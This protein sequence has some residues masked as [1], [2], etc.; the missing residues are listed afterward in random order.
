MARCQC[1]IC[2]INF[3]TTDIFPSGVK[4]L[5]RACH[6]M[7]V[8]GRG[9]IQSLVRR[10]LPR[11]IIPVDINSAMAESI[12]EVRHNNGIRISDLPLTNLEMDTGDIYFPLSLPADKTAVVRPIKEEKK[13][14]SKEE[15]I[16]KRLKSI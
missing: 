2:A 9:S 10:P 6:T 12:R 13:I 15:A 8:M 14:I 3:N 16:I 5:C 4:V 7:E 11:P 1:E